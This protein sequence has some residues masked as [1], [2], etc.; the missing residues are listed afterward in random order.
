MLASCFEL[1][2]RSR[3]LSLAETLFLFLEIVYALISVSFIGI[4]FSHFFFLLTEMVTA[5]RPRCARGNQRL[6]LLSP[7]RPSL[8]AGR[9]RKR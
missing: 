9:K 7:H 1:L 8:L 5:R 2:Q 3:I 6:L 4:Y